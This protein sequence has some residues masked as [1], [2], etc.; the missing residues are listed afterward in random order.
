MDYAFEYRRYSRPF[1]TPPRGGKGADGARRGILVCLRTE[2]GA[3]SFGE[4]APLEAFGTESPERAEAFL[5]GIGTRV[6]PEVLASCSEDLPCCRFALESALEEIERSGERGPSGCDRLPVA[7]L[8]PAGSG[9]EN[10]VAVL[11]EAGYRTLKWKIGAQSFEVERERFRRMRECVPDG[12]VWRLDANGML[13]WKTAVKW[14]RELE[15]AA[16]EYLEQPLPPGRDAELLSLAKNFPVPVALDESVGT[17][18][19]LHDWAA[20]G[21]PGMFVVKPALT[22]APS[23]L[24]RF[25]RESGA[26]VVFS[27]GLETGIG[28]RQALKTAF[29][30]GSEACAV[31]WGT[32]LV[33]ADDG[34]SPPVGPWAERARIDAIDSDAIWGRLG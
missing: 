9:S 12:A 31:G 10:D 20:R 34:L 8:L 4:A 15:G 19:A 5:R 16:V 3:R 32:G 17:L 7:G 21:W 18:P 30:Y 27:S 26:R 28:M 2:S 22:G 29:S 33:F 13:D 14:G 11:L 6:S 24:R 23:E 25:V 1:R